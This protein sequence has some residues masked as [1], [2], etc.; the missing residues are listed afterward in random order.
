MSHDIICG[1][2]GKKLSKFHTFCHIRCLQIETSPK[3]FHRVAKYVVRF[4]DEVTFKFEFV[5]KTFFMGNRQYKLL[6]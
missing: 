1:G 2:Y 5:F 4:V 3:K 6:C